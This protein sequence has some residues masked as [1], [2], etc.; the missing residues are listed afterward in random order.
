M[1][2]VNMKKIIYKYNAKSVFISVGWKVHKL[3][4]K[5]WF[6]SCKIFYALCSTL[7][8]NNYIA[9]FQVN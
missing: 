5:E 9:Y 2:K 3:T 8:I 1:A 7:I 6:W 4:M